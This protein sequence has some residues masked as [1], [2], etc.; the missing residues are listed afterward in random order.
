[1]KVALVTDHLGAPSPDAA[2]AYPALDALRVLPLATALADQGQQ[3]TVYT[4]QD[5]AAPAGTSA[6]RPGVT[7]CRVPAG[8]P[9]RLP[10][11]MLLPHI[12]AMAGRLADRWSGEAPDVIH[13]HFWTSGLAA[14]AGARD[15]GIPVVQTF[16]ALG[17]AASPGRVPAPP[18]DAARVRLEAAIA[19]SV[20]VVL[21]AGPQERAALGRLGVPPASVRIVPPGVDITRFRPSGPAAARGQRARLL[22]VSPPGDRRGQATALQALADVPGAE[23][24]IAGG[25]RNQALAALARRLAVHDRL[26]CLGGVTDPDLPPLMR[27]ADVLV[28]LTSGPR[29]ATV[30]VEAMACGI[31]VVAAE[32]AASGDAV[33]HENTG[34]LVPPA[35][36]GDLA[37]RLRQLLASPILRE[38]YGIAAAN[39]AASRYSWERIGQETL[40]VY[41]ALLAPPMEAAA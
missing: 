29:F 7:V 28:H 31:P 3:V 26:I 33:I 4:R 25:P 12:A 37:R 18:G 39:R 38:G 23:L 32:D 41:E 19:R 21:A 27:S 30:P 9:E 24:V 8:P 1:M 5:C 15:L 34:F 22:M 14:L 2:D 36:P 17:D 6:L 10:G 20:S 11:P 35:D 13:A 40:A 16:A